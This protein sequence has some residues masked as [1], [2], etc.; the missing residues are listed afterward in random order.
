MRSKTVGRALGIGLRVAGSKLLEPAPPEA[1]EIVAARDAARRAEIAAKVQA[2][3]ER[4][5]RVATGVGRGTGNFAR[6]VWN[7]FALATGVLWLEIT[8]AF[9]ALF[10]LFF[11]QHLYELRG[12]W[13]TNHPGDRQHLVLY[14]GLVV[15]FT[16]FSASSFFRAHR[17]QKRARSGQ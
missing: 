1:P 13:A 2:T 3:G 14:A 9:F 11:A 7:P 15:L 12:S 6:A 8:G 4:S 16:Y 17:K 10:A 5:R